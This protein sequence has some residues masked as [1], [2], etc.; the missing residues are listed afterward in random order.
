M[1]APGELV[2]VARA[3]IDDLAVR[4]ERR[5]R[6][7]GRALVDAARAWAKSRGAERLLVRVAVHNPEGQA[8]WRALGWE[9][10]VD[11]LQRRL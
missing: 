3:E 4:P 5:R 11:I 9:G 1:R 2:E 8:F 6:G 7:V 10:F